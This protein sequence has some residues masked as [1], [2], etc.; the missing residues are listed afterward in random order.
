M[1]ICIYIYTYVYVYIYV[2]MYIYICMYMWMYICIYMYVYIY[3]CILHWNTVLTAAHIALH[4]RGNFSFFTSI[5][6][7]FGDPDPLCLPRQSRAGQRP[8]EIGPSTGPSAEAPG[9]R[10]FGRGLGGLVKTGYNSHHGLPK[11]F[12]TGRL[13]QDAILLMANMNDILDD[14]QFWIILLCGIWADAVQMFVSEITHCR[15]SV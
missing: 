10:M 15:L 1:Y 4:K 9:G 7:H 14:K 13:C 2:C 8:G 3:I 5:P 12:Q 11:G 6:G